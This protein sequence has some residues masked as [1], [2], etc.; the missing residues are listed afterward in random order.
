[1][2]TTVESLRLRELGTVRRWFSPGDQVLELGGGTG[3]QASVI[4]K[5]NCRVRSLDLP[6]SRHAPT[7][8]PVERYDGT[9]IP[10][11]DASMDLVFSSCVLEH[12]EAVDE[13][14]SEIR[15]VLKPS[16]K[17]IHLVPT[18]HWRMWTSAGYY[19]Y[20]VKRAIATL[21][22]SPHP[23][24]DFAA[25]GSGPER[26]RSI[27]DYLR[28]VLP[29]GPHGAHGSELAELYLYSRRHWKHLFRSQGFNILDIQD[30]GIFYTGCNLFPGIGLDARESLA[31]FL[32]SAIYVF[33]LEV[34]ASSSPQQ[35]PR[36]P[37]IGPRAV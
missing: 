35:T 6:T 37:A 3:F 10:A 30:G 11:A 8:F 25:G 9:H 36:R 26:R 19:G 4:A 24:G 14:A 20:L 34:P 1:M 5:W 27:G 31:R 12:V 23:E 21:E 22:R 18:P 33:V 7:H 17:A 29:A 13:L 15:R 32:G 28:K 2:T 16:G